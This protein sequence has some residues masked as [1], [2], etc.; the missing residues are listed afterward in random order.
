[1]MFYENE[2]ESEE[3]KKFFITICFRSFICICWWIICNLY[4]NA[5]MKGENKNEKTN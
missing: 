5:F 2:K 1:M 4:S 3:K